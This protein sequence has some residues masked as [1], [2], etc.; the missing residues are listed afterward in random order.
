MPISGFAD[1]QFYYQPQ[2]DY[3]TLNRATG[4]ACHLVIP[5]TPQWESRLL[6]SGSPTYSTVGVPPTPQWESHPEQLLTTRTDQQ[7]M[8]I[9]KT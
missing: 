3:S 4:R 8:P 5:P 6:H 7:S 1:T 2:I 9:K